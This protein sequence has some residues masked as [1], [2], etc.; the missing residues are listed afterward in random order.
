[1]VDNNKDT[2]ILLN[3][4]PGPTLR[5]FIDSYPG[6]KGIVDGGYSYVVIDSKLEGVVLEQFKVD[7]ANNIVQTVSSCEDEEGVI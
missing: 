1:M 5:D 3:F 6:S 2:Q 7:I 4:L